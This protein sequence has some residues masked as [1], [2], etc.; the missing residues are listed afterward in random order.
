MLKIL[1]ILFGLVFII[2]GILGFLPDYAPNEKLFEMFTADLGHNVLLI[3]TGVIA[4]LC[5]FSSSGASRAFFILA[6]L[7][8][9]V[10]AGLGFYYGEGLLYSTLKVNHADNWLHAGISLIALY[11]GFFVRTK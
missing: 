2:V 8:Y 6:G 5:G 10:I 3:T 7:A 4:L 11:F 9:A 1:A